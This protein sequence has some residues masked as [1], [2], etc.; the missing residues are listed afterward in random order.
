MQQPIDSQRVIDLKKVWQAIVSHRKAF[1]WA[2]PITFV[3][4]A[5]LILC[6][7]RYFRCRVTLAP[8][9]QNVMQGGAL[10]SIANSFGINIGSSSEDAIYPTLYPDV[11]RSTD[12]MSGLFDVDVRTADGTFAGTYYEYLSKHYRRP[13][14]LNVKIQVKKWINK[15]RPKSKLSR[16]TTM[17][18]ELNTFWFSTKQSEI[19][20]LMRDNITCNVDKRTDV[21][22]ISVMAQDPLVAATMADSVRMHLQAFMTEY[23]TKKASSDMVYYNQLMEEEREAYMQARKAFVNYSDSHHDIQQEAYRVEANYLE[24]EMNL[25]YSAF[26]SYQKQ[27]IAAQSKLQE[28]TPI[29]TTLQSAVVPNIPDG[30]KR[31]AFVLIMLFLVTSAM[32]LWYA[33]DEIIHS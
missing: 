29:Y 31:L 33:K 7:P 13:F 5:A 8:E 28:N 9:A 27:Y 11:I 23:R 26:T 22:S 16:P 30:P 21:V 18:D 12:F 4:S 3:V 24:E 10:S 32:M 2:L 15:L 1:Y 17:G 20:T 6:V 14:W 25:H 19:I